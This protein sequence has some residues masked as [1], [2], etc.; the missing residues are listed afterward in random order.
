MKTVAVAVVACAALSLRSS[1]QLSPA[2][3]EAPL[4]SEVAAQA[5][6]LQKLNAE[7][8]ELRRQLQ[9]AGAKE[10]AASGIS[11]VSGVQMGIS[12]PG[13]A[14]AVPL[15]GAAGAPATTAQKTPLII[16][17]PKRMMSFNNLYDKM[18]LEAQT[19]G[20]EANS[21]MKTQDDSLTDPAERLKMLRKEE[22]EAAK[23]EAFYKADE[24][25]INYATKEYPKGLLGRAKSFLHDLQH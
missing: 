3:A 7:I 8:A 13:T 16:V 15:E 22:E 1:I 12:Y 25:E 4:Q 24:A 10:Q 17:A 14:G 18:V 11:A 5:Q 20:T 23:M 21:L 19:M 2:A 6:A 9:T